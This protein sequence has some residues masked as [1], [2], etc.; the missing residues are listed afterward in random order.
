MF[1]VYIYI[2]ILQSALALRTMFRAR[3]RLALFGLQM[4]T[5]LNIMRLGFVTLLYTH[6]YRYTCNPTLWI[7]WIPPQ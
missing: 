2:Y 3:N 7:G 6:L 5:Q 4:E 1:L